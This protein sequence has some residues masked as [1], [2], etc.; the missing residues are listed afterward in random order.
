M[1]D[2]SRNATASLL[3]KSIKCIKEEI[4]LLAIVLAQ[5][6]KHIVE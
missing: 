6:S 4:M 5:K 1:T 2:Q 3:I